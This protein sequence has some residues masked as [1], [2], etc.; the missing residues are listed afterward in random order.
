VGARKMRQI[1]DRRK[2]YAQRNCGTR[3]V[4]QK[5]KR[6]ITLDF[7][8]NGLLSNKMTEQHETTEA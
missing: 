2:K 8:Q 6:Q 7:V 4:I 3:L 5:R 1:K